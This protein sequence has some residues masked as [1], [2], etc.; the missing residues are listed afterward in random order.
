[1][2]ATSMNAFQRFFFMKVAGFRI[3]QFSVSVLFR[4]R[5]IISGRS[6]LSRCS[7]ERDNWLDGRY[8]VKSGFPPD[9]LSLKE[10]GFDA[11]TKPQPYDLGKHR[12]GMAL[13]QTV[14]SLNPDGQSLLR[15]ESALRESG[16]RV[17]S[18]STPLQARFEIEM[19]RCGTFLTTDITPPAIYRDLAAFFKRN[20]PDGL[21]VYVAEQKRD[22]LPVADLLVWAR[23]EPQ[24]VVRQIQARQAEKAS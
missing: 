21:V 10:Y 19:G 20:C 2:K 11:P 24:A 7:F 4:Q 14:L 6:I 5:Q 9:V 1:M 13:E 3:S 18:V 8:K 15:Q 17:V 22:G 23:D 12:M 16:F